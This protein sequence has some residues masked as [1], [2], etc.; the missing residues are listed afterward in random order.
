LIRIVTVPYTSN[1]MWR[2]DLQ[3]NLT[4]VWINQM[5]NSSCL[6]IIQL[7][8]TNSC[9]HH[10]QYSRSGVCVPEE[11]RLVRMFSL[12]SIDLLNVLHCNLYIPLE[13]ILFCG[14]LSH[15]WLH[16]RLY[17]WNAMLKSVLLKKLVTLY[18]SELCDM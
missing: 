4:N 10:T 17:N 8:D 2:V 9:D 7:V 1:W 18:M 6:L 3:T 5:N 13:F 12:I 15:N 14:V 11:F 16:I